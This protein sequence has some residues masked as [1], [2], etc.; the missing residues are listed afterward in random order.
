MA[1]C[2]TVQSVTGLSSMSDIEFLDHAAQA[3]PAAREA[4]WRSLS[5]SKDF[6][7]DHALRLALLESFPGHSGYDPAGA[8][9]GLRAL[10]AQNPSEQAALAARLRLAGMSEQAG[11]LAENADLKRRLSK[12]VDIERDGAHH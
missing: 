1:G 2:A 6:G 9:R 3:T 7:E 4:E 8:Q 12:L 11:L 10:L 5:T